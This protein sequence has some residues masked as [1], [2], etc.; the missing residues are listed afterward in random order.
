MDR[1]CDARPDGDPARGAR[2]HFV[3][4]QL[5]LE[6]LDRH[7]REAIDGRPHVAFITGEAGIGKTRLVKELRAV[8]AGAGVEQCYGRCYEDLTFPYLPFID[9]LL[10]HLTRGSHAFPPTLGDDITIINRLVHRD[11]TSVRATGSALSTENN[12]ERL[13]LFLAVS[14]A[15]I[16]CAQQRPTLVVLED[17]HWAD[18]SSL[19]LFGHLVAAVADASIQAAIPLMIIATHR[20]LAADTKA[21]DIF[22]RLQREPICHTLEP[23]G[24]NEAE[25]A[26]LISGQGLARPAPQL[27]TTVCEATQGNPLFIEEVV[28]HLV[29]Q[30][31]VEDRAGQMI[32]TVA[33][34]ELKFPDRITGMIAAR[35]QGLSDPCRSLLTVAACLGDSVALPILRAAADASEDVLLELLDDAVRQRLIVSEAE[36]FQFAHPLIRHVFYTAPSA[37]QRQVLHRQIADAL[38]RLSLLGSED[39]LLEITHHLIGAG[40]SADAEKLIQYARRAGEHAFAVGAW[41]EAASYYGAALSAAAGG[42]ISVHDRADLHYRTGLA[43][44]RDLDVGPC[45]D[46]YGK[47]VDAYREAGHLSGLAQALMEQTRAR[48]SLGA[49]Q[50]GTRIDTQPL[51]AVLAQLGE[52]QPAL[53]GRILS[54]LAEVRCYDRQPDQA[55][56]LA[57]QA[58]RIGEQIADEPLCAHACH[59]LGWAHMDRMRMHE[60]VESWQGSLAHARRSKDRWVLGWPLGRIPLLLMWLGRFD[61]A[62][63]VASEAL[64]VTRT[65]LDWAEHSLALSVFASHFPER[66]PA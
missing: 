57:H 52:Q 36:T 41:S 56:P 12:L 30:G 38:E 16:A 18:R 51:E 46:E 61:E 40:S 13:Q 53:R 9:G 63:A 14:R 15:T 31:V 26:E 7:L 64:E 34:A 1:S 47:S 39:H 65:S 2:A 49:V 11:A 54:I 3:G 59:V 55:A 45:I 4:R 19:E 58:L 5:E 17:L 6:W 25:V 22:S 66:V 48:F 44:Y 27:V 23:R 32:A 24:L 60:A 37:A 29:L 50:Y 35:I 20:P 10:A 62:C 21:A 43:H 8:A 42:R 28:H 33:P